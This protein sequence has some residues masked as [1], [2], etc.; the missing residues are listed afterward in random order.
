MS[1]IRSILLLAGVVSSV[2]FAYFFGHG[3]SVGNGKPFIL[4][5]A[6]LALGVVLLTLFHKSG[7]ADGSARPH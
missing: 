7:R 1:V 3:L 4:A 6:A 5:V 2:A